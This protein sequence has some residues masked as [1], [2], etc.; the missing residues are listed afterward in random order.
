V[1]GLPG[2]VLGILAAAS[3]AAGL[4]LAA[5]ESG[6]ACAPG[7]SPCLPVRADLDCGQIPNAKKPVRVRG[8]DPYRLDADR[9]GLG[10]VSGN[11]AGR[12]SPWGLILR[13]PPGK[14]ARR[15]KVGDNLRV[16]GWSP[17]SFAGQRFRLCNV[18]KS[19]NSSRV[20]CSRDIGAG[21]RLTGGVQA[22]GVWKVRPQQGDDGV[23]KLTLRVHGKV[24]AFDTVPLR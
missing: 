16:V 12:Q 5:P 4:A 17:R 19:S 2:L 23:F 3:V 1:V 13:K 7:Y 15:A 8:R 9:D 18:V 10:C 6:S 20:T 14:E 24:R 21:D 11:G 22:L